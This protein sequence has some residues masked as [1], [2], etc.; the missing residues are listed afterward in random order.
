VHAAEMARSGDA[1]EATRAVVR[2]LIDEYTA[3]L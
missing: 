2:A 1:E 3:D